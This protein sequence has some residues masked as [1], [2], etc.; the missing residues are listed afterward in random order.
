MSEYSLIIKKD[1]VYSSWVLASNVIEMAYQSLK[2]SY[3]KGSPRRLEFKILKES[4]KK[5]LEGQYYKNYTNDD[6]YLTF[7][8]FDK[9]EIQWFVNC[10]NSYIEEWELSGVRMYKNLAKDLQNQIKK[11]D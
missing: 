5:Q 10:F 9:K 7:S 2:K 3:G 1:G 8:P 11:E 4:L 6:V